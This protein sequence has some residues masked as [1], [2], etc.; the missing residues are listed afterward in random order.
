MV[1]DVSAAMKR[2]AITAR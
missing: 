1:D 2:S